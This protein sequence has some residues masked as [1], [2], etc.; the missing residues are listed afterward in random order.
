[1]HPLAFFEPVDVARRDLRQRHKGG[2]GVAHV[3]QA[4]GIPGA[5][6]HGRA[7]RQFVGNVVGNGAHH[8][9]DHVAGFGCAGRHG[10]DLYRRN[11]HANTRRENVFIGLAALVLV[12]QHKAARVAQ[13]GHC[14]H[15]FHALEGR[16]HHG[17]L[18]GHFV[19]FV[20][21]AEVIELRDKEL[22]FLHPGGLGIGDP[23]HVAVAHFGLQHRFTVAH[24]AQSQVA[25][26]GLAGDVSHGHF[27]AQFALA[28]VGVQ[29]ERKLVGRAKAAG[30]RHGTNH[31]RAG[32]FEE[33]FVVG[34]KF[35]RVV[36]AAHRVG[37]A[38]AA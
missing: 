15:R 9:L 5:L 21:I 16:Q 4:N 36:H 17:Q 37:K 10:C 32:V 27:V 24:A 38:P 35:E 13:I 1:M 6:G 8:A 12:N 7:A 26:I 31:Q 30:A 34:K 22:A 25:N 28:Q 23:L 11:G 2:A 29:D 33:V 20:H 18:E 19:V 14:G 3:G